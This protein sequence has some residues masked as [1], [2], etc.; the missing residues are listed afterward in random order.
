M[1][2]RKSKFGQGLGPIRVVQNYTRTQWSTYLIEV[3]D[4][5]EMVG[6]FIDKL[7]LF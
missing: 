4:V 6:L 5:Q 2:K 1:G 7:V 3:S